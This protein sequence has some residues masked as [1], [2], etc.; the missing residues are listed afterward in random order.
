MKVTIVD[1]ARG[2][3]EGIERAGFKHMQVIPEESMMDAA[4]ALFDQGLNVMLC[5]V[6]SEEGVL[7]FVDT[8]RFQQR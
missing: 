1:Y 5:H 8:M 4:K 7:L 2:A 3:N 6:K